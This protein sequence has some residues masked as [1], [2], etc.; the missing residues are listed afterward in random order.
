MLLKIDKPRLNMFIIRVVEK[1]Q[2]IK[3]KLFKNLHLLNGDNG[4]SH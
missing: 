2:K 3:N 4:A 1:M